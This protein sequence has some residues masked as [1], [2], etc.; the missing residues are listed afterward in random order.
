MELNQRECFHLPILLN[1]ANKGHFLK[2]L[3][4]TFTDRPLA[5]AYFTQDMYRY[6]KV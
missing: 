1:G 3:Y 2:V 6:G 4:A 5:G